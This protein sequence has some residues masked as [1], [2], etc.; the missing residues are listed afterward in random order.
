MSANQAL[1][2]A[3]P[4][5][6]FFT[7]FEETKTIWSKIV[8]W[9]TVLHDPPGKKTLSSNDQ[10][11]TSIYTQLFYPR[12][13][14]HACTHEPIFGLTRLC[15]KKSQAPKA[16]LAWRG[17]YKA[18]TG[19]EEKINRRWRWRMGRGNKANLVRVRTQ[20]TAEQGRVIIGERKSQ[21]TVYILL[22]EVSWIFF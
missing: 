4:R 13:T 11:P 14:Q 15:P 17:S 22:Y 2:F 10:F 20:G 9:A 21:L 18:D 3:E 12:L 6:G 1:I 5:C 8:A 16:S 7:R 19:K